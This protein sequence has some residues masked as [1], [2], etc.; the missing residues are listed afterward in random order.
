MG[1]HSSSNYNL[2]SLLLHLIVRSYCDNQFIKFEVNCK[3]VQESSGLFPQQNA[4][5]V[6]VNVSVTVQVSV[7]DHFLD[8]D[9]AK[10]VC[11]CVDDSGQILLIQLSILVSIQLF[12]LLSQKLVVFH[13]MHIQ[14]TSNEL[15][16]VNLTAFIKIHG[17]EHLVQVFLLQIYVN[18]FSQ[19]V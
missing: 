9:F 15:C 19:I 13:R 12:K 3:S 16:V 2:L 5:F 14:K 18:F 1:C 7:V 6:I 17:L 10:S 4:E 11:I 8:V